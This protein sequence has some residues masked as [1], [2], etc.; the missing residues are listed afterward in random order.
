MAY[1][2]EWNSQAR[3]S[4]KNKRFIANQH[5]L[6]HT[7]IGNECFKS[8]WVSI[9]REEGLWEQSFTYEQFEAVELKH[10]QYSWWRTDEESRR[11]QIP[12]QFQLMLDTR[13][14]IECRNG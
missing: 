11:R 8:C 6:L 14:I 3:E 1:Q 7:I 10:D 13:S 4:W 5:K 12:S 2:D 9:F